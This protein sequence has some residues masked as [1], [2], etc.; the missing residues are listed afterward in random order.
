MWSSLPK[1]RNS[2]TAK[3]PSTRNLWCAFSLMITVSPWIHLWKIRSSWISCLLR[4]S[5]I[6]LIPSK[7]QLKIHQ[8]ARTCQVVTRS[9]NTKS[10]WKARLAS[11]IMY[12]I[13]A[14]VER[15][16]LTG[17]NLC[18]QSPIWGTQQARE[19]I[20]RLI[21]GLRSFIKWYNPAIDSRLC[22]PNQHRLRGEAK[23]S[24][25]ISFQMTMTSIR[26]VKQQWFP[27]R[28]N[29]RDPILKDR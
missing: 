23:N 28:T 4:K 3:T 6:C 17:I 11:A 22:F 26:I 18:W 20:A 29:F 25:P 24:S 1:N 19:M 27:L 7:F 12:L 8:P 10:T 15:L 5:I 13:M 14:S 21:E 9:S 2:R 16:L